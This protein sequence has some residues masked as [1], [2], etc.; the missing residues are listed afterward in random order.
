MMTTDS[1]K[2]LLAACAIAAVLF[3]EAIARDAERRFEV[4]DSIEMSHFG[5]I[6]YSAP[7]DLDDDGVVSPDGRYF[8]KVTHRGVLPKGV[9]EGTTWLFD[10]RSIQRSLSNPE[11]DVPR[12]IASARMSATANGGLGINVLD[13]GNTIT[14]P[15]WSKD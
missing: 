4:R 8:V 3:A 7:D 11:L 9:T 6:A 1:V 10:T 12:P 2:R 13:A 14:S 15:Q 5:T